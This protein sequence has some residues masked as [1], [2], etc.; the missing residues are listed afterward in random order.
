MKPRLRGVSHQVAFFVS[1]ATGAALLAIASGFRARAAVLVYALSCSALFGVSALYH[2]RD[3]APVARRW[4][5]RLDHAMIFVFIAG[6]CTPVALLALHG[7]LAVLLL[8]V[9]WGGALVGIALELAWPE[10]PAWASAA[11][12]VVLG[13]I[14]AVALG[15]LGAVVGALG[16][17]VLALGGLLYTAGAVVYAWERP[18]P[19][20]RTFGYHEVFHAFV[21]AAAAL[22]YAVIA[23]AVL[24]HAHG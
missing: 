23:F 17:A 13:W 7:T 21:L 20:P 3:W 18:N 9:V 24:P 16:I 5:R 15:Q 8:C 10:R 19:W 11:A 22:H 4:M 6:T 1:L 14:G 12:Y 2:R